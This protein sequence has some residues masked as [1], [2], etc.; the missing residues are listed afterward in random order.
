M[1]DTS[2]FVLPNDQPVVSLDCDEAF[3]ALSNQEK[4]YAHHLS[5]ASWTGGL[6]VFVQVKFSL[7][8]NE[9][10][11]A[12]HWFNFHVKT[13]PESPLIFS[14]LHKLFLHQSIDDLKRVATNDCKLSEDEFK[15]VFHLQ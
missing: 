3:S 10:L 9:N 13:S 11:F 5:Q 4:L 1:A 15:V 7:R 2:Q 6:I 12:I 14:L 8:K